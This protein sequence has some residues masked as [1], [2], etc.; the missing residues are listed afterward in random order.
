MEF[1]FFLFNQSADASLVPTWR[2]IRLVQQLLSVQRAFIP[3]T[4][5]K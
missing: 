2:K 3:Q 5:R 4:L 1:P